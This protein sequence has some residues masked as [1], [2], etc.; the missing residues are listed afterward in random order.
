MI[1]AAA[2][3]A[4]LCITLSLG[5]WPFHTPSNQVTWLGKSN[6]IEFGQY[7]TVWSEGPLNLPA[8]PGSSGRSIEILLRPARWA[9]S[10]TFLSFYAP[11][12]RIPLALSQSLTALRLDANLHGS[13]DAVME[14]TVV[15][16][17]LGEALR[18]KRIVLL[19]VTSGSNGTT[20]YVDGAIAG[21]APRFHIPADS[22]TGRMVVGDIPRQPNSF[23][24]EIRGLALFGTELSASEVAKDAVSWTREGRPESES[25]PAALYLFAERSG[26]RIRNQVSP[27]ADL[28]IPPKYAV[29]DKIVLEPFWE[30]FNFTRSYW[31]SGGKNIIGFMPFGFVFYALLSRMFTARKAMAVTAFLGA[32]TSLTIEVG[33]VFLPMRD[34]G[35]TDL[36]TNTF[37]T[38]LG[39]LCFRRLYPLAER[40]LPWL[41]HFFGNAASREGAAA[42]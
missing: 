12:R 15:E 6:G 27:G 22:F 16:G 29:L 34:S 36:F 11:G 5:F 20:V 4:V 19:T 14:H 3:F 25:R 39:A 33:Q 24:G 32:M 40:Q 1:L 9:T 17:V 18:R 42:R 31:S 37:G 10:A 7:G 26:N 30:E 2:C 38:Y 8:S 35:T 13:I 41:G 21:R 28:Y 23:S